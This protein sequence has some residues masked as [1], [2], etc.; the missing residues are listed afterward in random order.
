MPFPVSPAVDDVYTTV[1]GSE[2]IYTSYGAWKANTGSGGALLN[3]GDITPNV[4][5]FDEGENVT[6]ILTATG[7]L[8]PYAF[9]LIGGA[10][11]AGLTLSAG[12]VIGG[13]VTDPG[14]TVFSFT[15][16]AVDQNGDYVTKAY[17]GTIG[18][19]VT[20]SISP[21]DFTWSN[22]L[23]VNEAVTGSGGVAPYTY[24][25]VA[26]SL[27]AGLSIDGNGNITGT[28]SAAG[29]A[30]Y[31]FT[32]R[33]ADNNGD[34]ADKTYTGTI[35]ATVDI[36]PTSF[37]FQ[38]AVAAS[39]I[40][41]ASGGL[42]PYTYS[43]SAGTI[44]AGLA[45][46]AAGAIT[47]TPTDPQGTLYDFTVL[48]TDARGNTVD[49]QYTGTIGSSV[50]VSVFPTTIGWAN[51]MSLNEQLSA[52][53]GTGPYTFTIV[54]GA[55]PNTVAMDAAGLVTGD[56]TDAAAT[57][58]DFT[59]R[60]TD[61]G[62]NWGE[63]QYTGTINATMAMSPQTLGI[64]TGETVS[65]TITTSN[66]VAPYTYT[67]I[68]GALPN[69]VTLSAAGGLGGT[70]T[71]PGGTAYDFTI[72]ATDARGNYVDTQYTGFVSSFYGGVTETDIL[73]PLDADDNGW[74]GS[75]L[76][77]SGTTL[78]I[79]AFRDDDD[80][81]ANPEAGAVFIWVKS[82]TTWTQQ[83]ELNAPVRFGSD[84]LG[85]DVAIDGDTVIAGAPNDDD[86]GSN[87]GCAYVY[88]RSGA[89]WTLEQQLIGSATTA[90]NAL[91]VS[92]AVSGDVAVVGAYLADAYGTSSGDAYVFT[93][94]GTAWTE[95]IRLTHPDIG[96]YHYF[97]GSAA[98][99]GDK[100][101]VG[102]NKNEVYV[103]HLIAGTWTFQQ[104]L[105][106]SDPS[107]ANGDNFGKLHSLKMDGNRLI[108]GS[109]NQDTDGITQ[110]GAAYIYE[111]D[112]VT[113]NEV[114]MLK[115]PDATISGRFGTT[116][117]IL[118]DTV[119]VGAPYGDGRI[120]D[121]GVA[122]IFTNYSGTWALDKKLVGSQ[123]RAS[124]QFANAIAIGSDDVFVAQMM[125]DKIPVDGAG[126][127]YVY[128]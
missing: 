79:G 21:A 15:V 110:S 73:Y 91:G 107:S 3:P 44:P 114:V 69:A 124:E 89:T 95:T 93:R 81:L 123:S 63:R 128:Q 2:F 127:V 35:G 103:F 55:L 76:A 14:G 111:W 94:S 64:V 115:N 66:G 57:A 120:L 125:G 98:I 46:S 85:N 18:A 48:A 118:G 20:I 7:G 106:P 92:V 105:V 28:V 86:A 102:C 8:A 59:V 36:T 56:I 70:V 31:A 77:I 100:L 108:V 32:V 19:A 50:L 9:S 87:A 75:A 43:V 11:P 26:G 37:T 74:F 78:A 60:A 5:A 33:V 38:N 40:V 34:Y 42:A 112:G 53:G 24:S 126:K 82:G 68:A 16:K 10:L 25:T 97:G 121:D 13:T 71:D 1:G 58:Y 101:A 109:G 113:W 61:S 62:G 99:D 104:K 39:E 22:G 65:E 116:T 119:V 4:L 41:S 54:G 80:V 52:S 51:G 49:R 72:R 88:T 45:L 90:G 29:G 96:A 122:Y 83:Q 84:R 17:T 6:Q 30:A 117:A 12:G 67:L 23:D 47:G 27:P